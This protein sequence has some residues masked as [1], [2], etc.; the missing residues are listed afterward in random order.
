MKGRKGPANCHEK[1]KRNSGRAGSVLNGPAN[2]IGVIGKLENMTHPLPSNDTLGR[3]QL[4]DPQRDVHKNAE[5][6]SDGRKKKGTKPPCAGE[7]VTDQ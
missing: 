6:V 3:V 5:H 2:R 1:K 7:R 4:W